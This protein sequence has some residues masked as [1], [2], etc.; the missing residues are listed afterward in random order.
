MI[1]TRYLAKEVYSTMLAAAVVLLLIFLS[2][3]FVR[4]MHFA[5]AGSISSHQVAILLLLQLPIFLAIL[6]PLSLYLGILLAYGRLYADSEIV[7]FSSCGVSPSKLL[8]TTLTFSA[9]II[10]IVALLTLWVNPKVYKYSDQILSGTTSS[11]LEVLI[12]NRFNSIGKGKWVFYVGETT[13]DKKKLKHIFAAEE[14][15]DNLASADKTYGVVIADSAYQQ[16]DKKSGDIYLILQNGSRYAGVPGQKDYQIMRYQ[17]YGV[18]MP[19]AQ[20]KWQPDASSTTT[21][22]LWKTRGNQLNAAELQWRLAMPLQV[23]ILTILGTLLSKIKPKKGRYA[24]LAPAVLLYIVYINLLFLAKAWMKK[25][26]L[27]ALVGM[28]WVHLLLL[29][30]ALMVLWQ[31]LGWMRIKKL[32]CK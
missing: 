1:L 25:G 29:L 5:A 3:Q 21:T 7:I 30:I 18:R 16:I 6:L 17:E 13:S 32:I 11:P 4:F 31:Q 19:Q 26:V 14:P 8:A 12:P 24:M 15:E 20:D 2:N 10:A 22:E 23:L 9:V 27:D 28:W